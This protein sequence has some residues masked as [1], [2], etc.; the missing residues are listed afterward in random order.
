MDYIVIMIIIINSV[1]QSNPEPMPL[2]RKEFWSSVLRPDELV[3]GSCQVFLFFAVHLMCFWWSQF[4]RAD[5]NT[6]IFLY[7][8]CEL[9]V[10]PLAKPQPLDHQSNSLI[11]EKVERI[12]ANIINTKVAQSICMLHMHNMNRFEI[13]SSFFLLKR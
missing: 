11:K 9:N 6:S 7:P 3:Q 1:Q 8:K 12:H 5:K 10:W 4:I 2:V 13:I